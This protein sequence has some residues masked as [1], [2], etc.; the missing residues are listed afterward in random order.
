M[1][2]QLVLFAAGG[3]GVLS[4]AFGLTSIWITEKQRELLRS[5]FSTPD[6]PR[7]AERAN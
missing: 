2:T 6:K 1:K 3:L 5:Y 7:A 4:R